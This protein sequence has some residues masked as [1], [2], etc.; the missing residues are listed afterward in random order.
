MVEKDYKTIQHS[1]LFGLTL[2]YSAETWTLM[3]RNNAKSNKL[4][5]SIR[6][7]FKEKQERIELEI[8]ILKTF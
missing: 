7:I 6:E 5:R 8:E 2:K 3:K 1:N 4:F